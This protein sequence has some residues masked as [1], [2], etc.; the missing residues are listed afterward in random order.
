LSK[1]QYGLNLTEIGNRLDLHKSTV[2]RLLNSL[3]N[4]GYIE[5]KT[6]NGMY[7]LGLGFIELCSLYLNNLE[8]K[9]EAEPFLRNLSTIT[10][11]TVY[12]AILQDNE[13]IYIDKYEQFNSIRKYS[14]IGNRRP[15]YCTSLGKAFL[16]GINNDKII[17]IYKDRELT[18]ITPQT[19]TDVESLIDDI[20]LSRNRGW[21]F[22]NEECEAD[23]QCI[24]APIYDYR[25]NIIAAI[26]TSANKN[27]LKDLK[28]ET[29]AEHV[30][31]TSMK[32]S[33]YM[34]YRKNS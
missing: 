10:T 23:I 24:G 4:R 5:K 34:G 16:M 27:I 29:V 28:L 33:R 11:Q 12:L 31:D 26:S 20:E 25:N 13:V 6:T 9:T 19:I 21:T 15:L 2:Y 32:I 22:D 18:F 7:R 1:E 17:E 3:K 14:V 8:L 30:L